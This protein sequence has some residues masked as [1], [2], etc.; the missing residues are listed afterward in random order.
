MK[1]D[2]LIGYDI[3]D[4]KRLRRVAKIAEKFGS[5][6]QYSF[7]HCFITLRQKKR[8]MAQMKDVIHED[9]DQVL[10]LPV[11]ERQLK[12]MEVVGFKIH[13]EAEGIIIV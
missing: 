8:M 7:F 6:V 10:F 2:Y 5:R 4:P 3:S 12:E 9:E 1:R 11:T 13:L